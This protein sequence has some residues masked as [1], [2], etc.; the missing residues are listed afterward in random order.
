[1]WTKKTSPQIFPQKIDRV[2]F[3][4]YSAHK[5]PGISEHEQP[6][7]RSVP[8]DWLLAALSFCTCSAGSNP[9]KAKLA[10]ASR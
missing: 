9:K 3:V 2:S 10:R 8:A 6:Q 4:Q 5:N 1:M 7:S